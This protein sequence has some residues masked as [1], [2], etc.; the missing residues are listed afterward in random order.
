MLENVEMFFVGRYIKIFRIFIVW[1]LRGC[2]CVLSYNCARDQ[3]K[4]TSKTPHLTQ[5][6][7]ICLLRKPSSNP[8]CP[9]FCCHGNEGCLG[10][11]S[12]GM[13]WWPIPENPP[14]DVKNFADNLYTHWVIVNF[15]PNF[16]AMATGVTRG[17]I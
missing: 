8:L 2:I 6:F 5:R 16:V 11:N 1:F 12:L 9:K 14:I 3:N 17:E 4:Q 7:S 10:K 13:I 15:V